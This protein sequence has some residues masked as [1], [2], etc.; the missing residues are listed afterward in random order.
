MF[1][2]ISIDT[3]T[4]FKS[5]INN[6]Q[7]SVILLMDDR[8]K[9]LETNFAV[10]KSFGY[11]DHDLIGKSFSV[12]FTPEDRLK[13][14]PEIELATVLENG[15][16]SDNNYI[17]HKDGAYIWVN[18][19]S[20]C[21]KDSFNKTF[22]VKLIFDINKQKL[23]E[24]HLI[25]SNKELTKIKNELVRNNEELLKINKE[26]EMFVYM[27]SHDLKAPLNNIEVMVNIIDEEVHEQSQS[28]DEVD[29]LMK[30]IK[31]SISRFKTTI[32]DL[33]VM[34]KTRED[35]STFHTP[36]KKVFDE[37]ILDL[38]DP[39]ETSHAKI[40]AD[41]SKAPVINY[42]KK[43][44]RSILYNLVSNAVKYQSPK[45]APEVLVETKIS[46]DLNYCIVSVTDNGLGIHEDDIEK[47]FSMYTRLH[48]HVEGT[49]VG[50][51]IVKK[52]LDND[53]GKMEVSSEVG[54]GS[55]FKVYLP[56]AE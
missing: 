37:V 44:L 29:E 24:N 9:I 51:S 42:S 53:N 13:S 23:L 50:M 43:N 30:M 54:K 48:N 39:I 6:S 36:F 41:F 7:L 31:S 20:I 10:H 11:T 1:N 4:F 27:A 18:G 33:G 8:G 55:V 19:E 22:I 3:S 25:V 2:N 15:S 17:L 34:A 49:G 35:E 56:L 32:D 28:K 47:I 16:A 14:K 52:I 38:K 46:D 5:L 26:L 12:L 21:V 40:L 45:R